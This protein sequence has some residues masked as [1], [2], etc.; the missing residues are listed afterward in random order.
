MRLDM[1]RGRFGGGIGDEGGEEMVV[2]IK[3]DGDVF[4]GGGGDELAGGVCDGAFDFDQAGTGG[5][6]FSLDKERHVDLSDLFEADGQ[7][8]A[9]TEAAALP[10]GG[11]DHGFVEHGGEEAAVGNVFEADVVGAGGEMG[12]DLAG[13]GIDEEVEVEAVG[14]GVAAD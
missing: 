14:V 7:F 8:A 6:D 10:G 13:L 1:V 12:L 11:P 4:G 2:A 9:D 5:G 3:G